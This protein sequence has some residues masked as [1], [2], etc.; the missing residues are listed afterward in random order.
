MGDAAVEDDRRLDVVVDRRDAGLDLGDHA[1]ADGA[2]GD[3]L[4]RRFDGQLADQLAVLVEDAGDVGQQEQPR[5]AD[6]LGDGAGHRVGI[7]VEALAVGAEADRRDHRDHVGNDQLLQHLRVDRARL[8]D[9]AEV[10]DLLD[11]RIRVAPGAAQLARLDQIAVLARDADRG[12]AGGVDGGDDL[13]VDLARQH[14]LDDF[15]R[16]LVGDAEPVDEVAFDVQPLQHG[17]D[18]GAA[19]VDHDRVDADPLQQH[20]VVGEVARQPRLAHRVAAK[21]DDERSPGIAAQIG[22]RLD[23]RLRRPQALL[24]LADV[25]RVGHGGAL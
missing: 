11:V 19:A 9:E 14:H 15:H 6:R 22:Q 16:R 18:L 23:Q 4:A 8:A 10:E 21:F 1:A 13:F 24:G 20:D 12:A 25:L 2:V 7:D 3:P 5:R 17:T